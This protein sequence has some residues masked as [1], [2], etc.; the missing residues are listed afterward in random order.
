MKLIDGSRSSPLSLIGAILLRRKWQILITFLVIAG[1]VTVVTLR[2]PKEYESRMKI[3]VKNERAGIVI[4]GSSSDQSL[5]QGEVSE[6][7][8]NT[9][10]ELLN[11]N[12]LL[13]QVVTA[14]GLDKLAPP[15]RRRSSGDPRRIAVENA[16]SNL[17]H[18]L[19][20]SPV[21]KA[22][23]IEVEYTS[24][25]PRQAVAVLRQ[26]AGSYLEAH[27]R[28]HGTPGTYDFFRNQAEHYRNELKNAE[29]NMRDFSLKNDIVLFGPQQEEMLRRASESSSMLLAAEAGIREETRKIS[30]A[31]RQL[32]AMQPRMI[33]QNHTL[34][35]QTSVEHLSTML[36]EL[37]NRRTQL[38]SKFR[39]E[40]RLVEEVS[41]EISDTGA[42]IER[43]KIQTA[44][45]QTT[46]VNP[47]RQAVLLDVT[48]EEADLAGLNERRQ[49]LK[50]QTDNYRQ[51][52][53]KLGESTGAYNDLIRRQKEA[54]DN[55][56]LY[57]R[58]TEEARI[59]DSLDK[60]K[61]ANVA[62]AENPVEP[63]HP[64]KPNVP[65]NLEM[66]VVLAATLSLGLAFGAEYLKQ[67]FPAV[68]P[69]MQISLGGVTGNQALLETIKLPADLESL[70]GLPVLAAVRRS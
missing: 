34:S 47:V 50:Q 37:Q 69:G 3:L 4:S 14:S 12:D 30:D 39:P 43:A 8:I 67:P 10:I 20:I 16:V 45:E 24:Q 59:A 60:Q 56:L 54:E 49:A 18:S 66:G 70:T 46:D 21:R 13:R 61:I 29:T 40:D 9:E 44:S 35:N 36:V 51:E 5:L 23:I 25:D 17:Q 7:E 53:K 64:S 63:S 58:K 41:Q 26:L 33:T 28:L 57:A 2:T 38:L 31:S 65:L 55:Y 62:I 6:T 19:K 11:S 52:L 42:A 32:A 27:L 22:D 15:P 48:K 1:G 68:E